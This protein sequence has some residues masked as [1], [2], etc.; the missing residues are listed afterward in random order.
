[1]VKV[2]TMEESKIKE[3]AEKLYQSDR[4]TTPIPPLTDSY[5]GFVIEDAYSVQLANVERVL[6]LGYKISG[7]KIGLTS[8]GMQIQ[9]GVDEPDYGHLFDGMDN[10]SDGNINTDALIQP[11]IEGELAFIL[12]EDL[13]GGKVT[14]DDVV[15]ATD[16]VAAAFEIVD[17]RVENWKIKLPDTVAD[18]ASSGRYVVS[19]LHLPV[20]AVD[21]SKVTMQLYKHGELIGEGIGGAVLGDP[22]IAVAWLANRLYGFGVSLNAGEVILSGAFSA[23]P[24]A[25]KGDEF[26]AKFSDFGDVRAKFI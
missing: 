8:E 12:K 4:T 2:K 16:Y 11:K 13:T 25:S 26:V 1:L 22:R 20:D 15:R 6:E 24:A 17:S 5:E 18:N 21:L 19:T 23:A 7:K 14:V 9:L 10:S 3:I